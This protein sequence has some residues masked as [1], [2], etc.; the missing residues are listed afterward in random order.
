[1]GLLVSFSGARGS[2]EEE[3]VALVFHLAFS[4]RLRGIW[5][6][7]CHF[8]MRDWVGRIRNRHGK[9]LYFHGK[10]Q[11]CGWQGEMAVSD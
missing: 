2:A 4:G 6:R 11:E 8:R 3:G 1:M 10:A 5:V 9:P 7:P